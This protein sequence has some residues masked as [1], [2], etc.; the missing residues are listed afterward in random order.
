MNQVSQKISL[1]IQKAGKGCQMRFGDLS[2]D[3]RMDILLIK[4]DS[5][6]DERYFPHRVVAATAY[7]LDGEILWQ[8]GNPEYDSQSTKSDI[9]VQIYDIDRD[10]KNEVILIMGDEL[11][12]LDGKNAQIKKSVPLPQ[13]FACDSITIADLD[14]TG[15]AQ[16]II[17]KNKYSQLWAFDLN[18]NILW[19]FSGNLGHAPV[20]YDINGDGYEEIIAGYNVIS[21]TGELLWKISMPHHTNSV[22]VCEFQGNDTPTIIFCGQSVK[23]YTSNGEF[24]WEIEEEAQ[25]IAV[26]KFQESLPKD[27]I[28]LLDSLS[29]F[30]SDGKFLLQKNETIYTPT[31]LSGF[32][33]TQ[34]LYII[35]YKK[36]EI[37]STVYDGYMRP[38][39]TLDSFGKIA[40]CDLLG[41][42]ITEVIIYNDEIADIYSVKITDFSEANRAFT[43]QQPRQCYNVSVH[44]LLPFSQYSAKYVAED[45]AAQ[46]I[47]KWAETYA[48][49]NMHNSFIKVTRSEFVLLL[50]TL[51]NLKEDFSENFADVTT[52]DTYYNSVGT[53]RALGIIESDDNMFRPNISVTVSY[54]NSILKKL[55]IPKEFGFNENYELSKQDLARLFLSLNEQNQ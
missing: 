14:G 52:E 51:L 15:Y 39:Y 42:G 48:N 49:I 29:I 3:G 13:K 31:V 8:I 33:D 22:C 10:G 5:V 9:P 23:A 17:I 30:D 32:D 18:L 11:L 12:I 19:T 6:I 53:A 46:N 25:N 26:G 7:S 41:D 38:M 35:G 24:L 16:N 45:F 4:P 28:L 44:N 36:D 27:Q 1:N 54:A 50:M 55:S 43:R 20:V 47:I 34:N 40:S 2:G 21:S 37:L